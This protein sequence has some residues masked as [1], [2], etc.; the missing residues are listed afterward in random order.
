MRKE[1]PFHFSTRAPTGVPFSY[2]GKEGAETVLV[3]E[4]RHVNA[5]TLVGPRP[6]QYYNTARLHSVVFKFFSMFLHVDKSGR[7]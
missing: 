1:N 7:H 3:V 4:V 2:I 6:C 5:Q